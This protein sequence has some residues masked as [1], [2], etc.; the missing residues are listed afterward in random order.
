MEKNTS[1]KTGELGPSGLA[2]TNHSVCVS[3]CMDFA[4]YASFAMQF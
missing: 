1:Y 3:V 4:E 2:L